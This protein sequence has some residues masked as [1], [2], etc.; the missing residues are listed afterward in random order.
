MSVFKKNKTRLP[1]LCM[2][3]ILLLFGL[4]FKLSWE[5]HEDS[6]VNVWDGKILIFLTQLRRPYLN[7]PAV[8]F[9]A[10][11]SA[12]VLTLFTVSGVIA[13]FLARDKRGSLYL[14]TGSIGG[15]LCTFV[16]KEVFTRERPSIVPRLVEVS[17]FSYPSGHSLNA[18]VFYLLLLIL[19]WRHFPAASPRAVISGCAATFI[20]GVCFSRLYLGV[21]YPSDVLSGIL[22]GS[23]WVCLLTCCFFLDWD[24]H[25]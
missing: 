9:T 10:L 11:G 13:L 14:A 18:T 21:H 16:M 8:D 22:L 25:K 7:G 5:M 17:G 15:G 19:G 3:L 23:A 2:G 6:T 1:F 4:F 12:T 24:F 20:G